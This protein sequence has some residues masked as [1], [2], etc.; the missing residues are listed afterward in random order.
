MQHNVEPWRTRQL[1]EERDAVLRE[2]RLRHGHADCGLVTGCAPSARTALAL[3]A[4][5]GRHDLQ[6]YRLKPRSALPARRERT[7]CSKPQFVSESFKA[8]FLD[9]FAALF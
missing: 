7:T 5:A 2:C 6:Q 9:N 3:W 4:T 1:A 8:P